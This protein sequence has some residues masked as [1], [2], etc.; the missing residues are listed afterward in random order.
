MPSQNIQWFPGHMAKTR[1]LITESLG[2]VDIVIELLDARSPRSSKNPEIDR[3]I[4]QKPRLTLLTKASLADAAVTARWVAAMP[5]SLAVD[6]VTGEGVKAIAPAVRRILAEKLKRYADR[7]MEGRTVKAMIV[8]IPNVGKSSLVNKLSGGKK[9]KVENRP[10]VT[11]TKQWVTTQSGIDLLDMP[12]VLWPK[13]DDRKIGERLAF[14]G[15][16]RD[17]ILDTEEL[18]SLLCAELYA[19]HA[20]L[21]CARYKLDRAALEGFKPFELLEAVAKKRGFRLSGGDFDTARAADMVLD[22]FREAKIGRI[23]LDDPDEDPILSE[24]SPKKG[25]KGSQRRPASP[26]EC[27]KSEEEEAQT[28]GRCPSDAESVE[29]GPAPA[30]EETGDGPTAPSPRE[31]SSDA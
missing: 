1:R 18:G 11:L 22:E 13:F 17:A 19:R 21:F 24:T 29:T 16:I 31:E 7:G 5:D 8:G 10:G 2:L 3:L 12:G 20:E 30:R 15:A 26:S 27:E 6:V 14:T 23:T 25:A 28:A 9:A 4:G